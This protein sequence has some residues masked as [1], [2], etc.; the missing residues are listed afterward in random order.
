LIKLEKGKYALS[1]QNPLTVASNVLVMRLEEILAE[2]VRAIFWRARARD[3]YDLWFLVK[4]DVSIKQKLIDEKL[5]YYEL[6]FSL[7]N[8][9]KKINEVGKSWEKELKQITTFVPEFKTV[10]KEIL[11]KFWK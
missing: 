8:F 3:V 4:K 1:N 9:E 5:K 2:K 6:K 10:K 7:K 11:K